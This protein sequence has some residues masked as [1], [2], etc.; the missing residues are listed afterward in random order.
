MSPMHRCFSDLV[1]QPLVNYVT[2][3]YL[4]LAMLHAI[5]LE[6]QHNAPH[7][8]VENYEGRKPMASQLEKTTRPPST[9]SGS[10]M[11]SRM[12]TLSLSTLWIGDR[13]GSWS[14]TTRHSDYAMTT[15]IAI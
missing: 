11:S 8:M 5:D 1:C 9:A 4:C 6:Y 2:D 13:Q 14:G 7:L 12:P 10:T 3:A 15:T